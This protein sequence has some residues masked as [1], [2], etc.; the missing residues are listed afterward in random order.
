MLYYPIYSLRRLIYA[1]SQVYL[2]DYPVLQK[3]SHL[4]LGFA[5]FLYLIVV[6]PYKQKLILISNIVSEGLMC[7]IFV[8]IIVM[9]F[10]SDLLTEDSFNFIFIS[11]LMACLG[12]QYII[13]LIIVGSHVREIFQR[14]IKRKELTKVVCTTSIGRRP[15]FRK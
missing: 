10:Y 5:T 2:S 9:H 4:A 3:S 7:L 11:I 8:Q 15:H 13:S 6:K 12:F 14:L 1:L